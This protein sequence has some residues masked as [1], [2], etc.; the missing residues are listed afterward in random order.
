[1]ANFNVDAM[2]VI[3]KLAARL[4]RAEIEAAQFDAA[5]EAEQAKTAE[6]EARVAE[7]E[8]RAEPGRRRAVATDPKEA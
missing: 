1:M 6:L 7:L 3:D 4:T 2:A 5:L 8:A